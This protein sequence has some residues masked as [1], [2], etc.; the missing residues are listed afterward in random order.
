M[1]RSWGM[2]DNLLAECYVNRMGGRFEV[3]G[4]YHCHKKAQITF[5]LLGGELF[6]ENREV[7]APWANCVAVLFGHY[8]DDLSDVTQIVNDP[9]GE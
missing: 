7:S 2:T 3:R 6:F 8:T 5:V 1:P 4:L 9:R